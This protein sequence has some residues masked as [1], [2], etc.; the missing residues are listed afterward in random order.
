MRKNSVNS[1]SS[2]PVAV[3]FRSPQGSPLLVWR[4][5]QAGAGLGSCRLD[6]EIPHPD[7]V[8][9]GQPEGK[10]PA[11]ARRAAVAGLA[12]QA[13]LLEPAEDLFDALAFPLAHQ[14]ADVARGAAIDRTGPVRG[15]LRHM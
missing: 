6:R 8:V 3:G 15:V 13:D 12:Q 2:G 9:D 1:A 14:I 5:G 10:H 4:G 7:E 11:D